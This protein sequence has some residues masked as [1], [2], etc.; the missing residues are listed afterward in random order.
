MVCVLDPGQDLDAE[1][2]AR[3]SMA[4]RGSELMI[5]PHLRR[6]RWSYRVISLTSCQHNAVAR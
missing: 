3:S 5:S 2:I 6:C 1:R 4:K